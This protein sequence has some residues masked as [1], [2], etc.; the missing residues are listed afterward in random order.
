MKRFHRLISLLLTFAFLFSLIGIAPATADAAGTTVKVAYFSLDDSTT[1][2]VTGAIS[3][4][5]TSNT[6]TAD[7][8]TISSVTFTSL[9][10]SQIQSGAL[11]SYDVL[12]IGSGGGGAITSAL[13]SKGGSAIETYVANGGGYVGIHGGA[14]AAVL[15]Y[16]TTTKYLELINYKADYPVSNHGEGQLVVRPGT[17][18]NIITEDMVSAYYVAY[19]QNPAVLT[20][21]S[22]SDSRMGTPIN[23]I[24][25]VSNARNNL[26]A[27]QNS[28]TSNY[29]NMTGT[30]AVACATFGSG[31]VAITGLQVHS[32]NQPADMDFMLGRMILYAA[33]YSTAS[34]TVNSASKLET[35]I[36]A[37]W[38][39]T[40]ELYYD[41][42]T[43]TTNYI[44]QAAAAGEICRL[45]AM[46]DFRI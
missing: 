21:G 34:A 3:D 42:K 1:A 11:S 9:T 13:G 41:G 45:Q 10:A 46:G 24:K 22:S 43:A 19:A 28:S 38:V 6:V 37:E 4:W 36:V 40:Q 8:T 33:G 7:G 27:S 20:V 29:V 14:Y 17:L 35:D 2:Q 32:N 18:D 23:L 25:Y 5:F 12:L 39:N 15:G 31:H 26:T 44:N 30:P 16:S